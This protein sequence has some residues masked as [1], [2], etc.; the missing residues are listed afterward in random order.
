ML[1]TV[2]VELEL[3]YQKRMVKKGMLM[4][5]PGNQPRLFPIFDLLRLGICP[6][7]YISKI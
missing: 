5:Q 3:K 7:V 2:G 1:R 4:S 6:S